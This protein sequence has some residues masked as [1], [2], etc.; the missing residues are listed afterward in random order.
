MLT[1]VK[2]SQ[3]DTKQSLKQKDSDQPGQNE[4]FGFGFQKAVQILVCSSADSSDKRVKPAFPAVESL[5]IRATHLGRGSCCS[6]NVL[7]N[8]Q[9]TC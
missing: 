2:E 1:N 8:M 4:D 5:W 6:L 9:L 7:F 3:C